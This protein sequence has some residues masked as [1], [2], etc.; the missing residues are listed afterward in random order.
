ML[1]G[2]PIERSIDAKTRGND[3]RAGFDKGW[4]EMLELN[5]MLG[6]EAPG[7]TWFPGFLFAFI[8]LV[9]RLHSLEHNPDELFGYIEAV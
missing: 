9:Q 5:S 7:T 8:N 3:A 6:A 2:K 1:A 4:V